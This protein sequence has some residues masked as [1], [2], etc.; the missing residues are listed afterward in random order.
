MTPY[1]RYSQQLD[2]KIGTLVFAQLRNP[3]SRDRELANYEK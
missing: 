2:G 1:T 3:G